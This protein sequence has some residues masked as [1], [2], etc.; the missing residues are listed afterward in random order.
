MDCTFWCYVAAHPPD[1]LVLVEWGR[2]DWLLSSIC[3]LP[4]R[5]FFSKAN[6]QFSHDDSVSRVLALFQGYLSVYLPHSRKEGND[7][8]VYYYS[9]IPRHSWTRES[10]AKESFLTT[11]S[12]SSEDL[13]R[14]YPLSGH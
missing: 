9:I 11:S 12:G 3:A 10:P 13:A 7:P 14:R 8:L 6:D 4:L 1:R 5:F 2:I